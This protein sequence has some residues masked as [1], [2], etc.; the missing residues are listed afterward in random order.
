VA[1]EQAEDLKE[2]DA[3]LHA[4]RYTNGRRQMVDG[5]STLF[6]DLSGDPNFHPKNVQ[7]TFIH[8]MNGTIEVDEQT[9]E[10]LDLD[11]RLDH[12]VKI[13][14][15]LVANVHKGFWLHIHQV[16]HPDGVWLP[17]M[18]EGKG[19]A[20]AV[21]FMHP[22]FQFKQTTSNCRLTNVTTE[23]GPATVVQP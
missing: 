20:R 9:G 1:K 4:L 2:L 13:G 14:G 6:Y 19:D 18:I 21:L 5:R 17:E 7:E 11:A 22:Y 8:N 23:T 12:D 10:L 16:R 3:M 15:G